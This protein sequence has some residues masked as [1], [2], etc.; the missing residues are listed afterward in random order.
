VHADRLRDISYEVVMRMPPLETDRLLIR[1]FVLDDL[2]NI[3]QILDIELS[4]AEFGN[5]GPQSRDGRRHWLEW[6]VRNYEELAKLYQPPYGD[7]AV[8][9]KQGSRL[10]GAI[11]YV[12]CLGPFAQLPGLGP[13]DPAPTSLITPEFGL[14]YAFSP[15]YQRQGHASEAALAMIDFAFTQLHLKR[16]IATTTHNNAASMG[17]MRKVGMRIAR[18]PYPEP[19]WLQVVGVLDN[20]S[21]SY[22]GKV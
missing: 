4:E 8:V 5:E 18:N 11:G 12:P 22:L 1:P 16:I 20:P 2:E 17:V 10:I 19:H 9:L 6:A 15:A 21:E 7:R 13:S 3:Y 14:Y